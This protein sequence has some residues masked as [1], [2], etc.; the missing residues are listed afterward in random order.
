[1]QRA[2]VLV[3]L[4]DLWWGI[5]ALYWRELASIAPADQLAWRI[6]LGVV[7]LTG[8]WSFRRRNP[9]SDLTKQH[10]AYGLAGTICITANWAMFLWAVANGQAVDAALGYFLTP[11]LAVA[12][13]VAVLKEHVDPLQ[14]VALVFA[15]AG[16]VWLFALE[17]GVPWVAIVLGASFATYGLVR[18]MGPWDAVGGLTMEMVA[19]VPVALVFLMVRGF[20]PNVSIGG[21]DQVRTWMLLLLAGLATAAP[22]V[23]FANAAR[24]A[25]LVV[26]G[27]MQYVIPVAQ[28][29]VGWLALGES[30]PAARFVGF[31][32]VWMA[33]A[34]VIANEVRRWRSRTVAL[35]LRD[36]SLNGT[37]DP[38]G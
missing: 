10:L 19:V 12:L 21:D 2:I 1:M 26:V 34:C 23:L 14:T 13:A 6:V 3:F 5:S 36:Q 16:L 7:M 18:K 22:L 33:I 4:A 24:S 35:S 20:D 17:G 25:P 32:L 9:F 37:A 8:W 29:L 30:V 27:L 11:V 38:T 31:G 15:V 28:F